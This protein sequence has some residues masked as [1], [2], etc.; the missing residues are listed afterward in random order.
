LI[1]NPGSSSEGASGCPLIGVPVALLPE[2]ERDGEESEEA[3]AGE[4]METTPLD[5]AASS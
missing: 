3:E 5:R 2:L 4:V 1:N